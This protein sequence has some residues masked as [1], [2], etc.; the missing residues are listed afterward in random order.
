MFLGSRYECGSAVHTSFVV[1][2]EIKAPETKSMLYT[3]YIIG[4][5]IFWGRGELRYIK[6]EAIFSVNLGPTSNKQDDK[7][8]SAHGAP[9]VVYLN[10]PLHN[11]LHFTNYSNKAHM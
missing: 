4:L 3:S 2:G 5:Y 10:P 9:N 7:R 8:R 11:L 1:C 6:W